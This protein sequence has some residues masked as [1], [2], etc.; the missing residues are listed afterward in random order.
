GADIMLSYTHVSVHSAHCFAWLRSFLAP[1]LLLALALPAGAA[2]PTEP[3]DK[4][5]IVDQP[6][7]VMVQPASV[8]LDGPRSVQQIVVTGK[9]ADDSV[10]D[11]T[12]FAELAFETQ[13]IA[14]LEAD[15]F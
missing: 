8:I 4:A 14:A 3:E 12:P 2:L 6:V 11:L 15:G 1:A 13:G 9:Y 10:R 7:S 5:K